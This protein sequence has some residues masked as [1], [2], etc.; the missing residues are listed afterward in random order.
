MPLKLSRQQ[1]V[2]KAQVVHQGRYDYSQTEYRNNK[3][4][5]SI[6][7]PEHGIF[8]QQGCSHLAGRGCPKCGIMVSQF[9]TT[10]LD[11]Y[12]VKARAMHGDRYDYSAAKYT[13]SGDK[14]TFIC[15]VHGIFEQY[16][17]DHL[18]GKGC[19]ECANTAN[20]LTIGEWL[21][22]A[23]KK[24]GDVYDYSKSV[25]VDAF[26]QVAIGC[27]KHGIFK[28]VASDHLKGS[29]C[30]R[31]FH[32]VSKPSVQWLEA[33]ADLDGTHI[34][35]GANGGEVRVAGTR[36]H[37]DGFSAELNKV[38]EFHGKHELCTFVCSAVG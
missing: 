3:E 21:D 6:K 28:Q 1:F 18:V 15:R 38:Y 8:L 11:Q 34:Q 32:R 23:T 2:D 30:P 22:R 29:G 7:C 35:H 4:K 14:M 33:M 27:R 20:R 19:R 13:G 31:C 5:V 12:L 10:T 16:A 24:H 9:R 17:G 37:A 25:Y 36:W 26:S